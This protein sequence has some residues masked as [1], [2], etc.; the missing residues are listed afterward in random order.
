MCPGRSQVAQHFRLARQVHVIACFYVPLCIIVYCCCLLYSH[1]LFFAFFFRKSMSP[2]LH[3]ILGLDGG[4]SD[5]Q[6]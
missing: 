6:T 4:R 5:K 3:F 2:T 1:Y